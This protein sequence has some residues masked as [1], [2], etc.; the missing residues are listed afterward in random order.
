[1]RIPKSWVPH[2]AKAII[3]RLLAEKLIEPNV[4]AEDLQ[5]IIETLVMDELM[6]EDKLNDEVREI[7]KKHEG[8]IDKGRL[9]YRTLFDLTFP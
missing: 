5:V 9:D 2:I 3:I 4:P 6:V 8:E 1:M 7:L